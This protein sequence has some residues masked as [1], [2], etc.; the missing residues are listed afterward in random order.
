[1]PLIERAAVPVFVSVIA[2][3]ALAVPT[4]WLAN[5]RLVGDKLTAGTATAT[6]VPVSDTACGLEAAL[7]VSVMPPVSVPAEVG[8]KSPRLCSWHSPPGSCRR[9]WSVHSCPRRRCR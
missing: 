8:L 2:C 4:V 5:V 3:T 6:A 7:S 1:M 9:Y